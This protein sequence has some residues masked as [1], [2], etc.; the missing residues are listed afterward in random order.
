MKS[1]ALVSTARIVLGLLFTLAG[2]SGFI[3]SFV[4]APP[5]QPGLAGQFQEVFFQSH[6]VLF[7]DG[8]Q[9]VSGILLLT[10]RYV[11][12]ALVLLGAVL[13]NIL[14]FHITMQPAGIVPGAI[15]TLLWARLAFAYRANLAPIFERLPAAQVDAAPKLRVVQAA[16]ALAS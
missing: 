12:L 11:P 3:L 8:V 5:P 14:T 16:R 15:A 6:W 4:G 7:V 13:S 10:N 2:A 9:L 1:A